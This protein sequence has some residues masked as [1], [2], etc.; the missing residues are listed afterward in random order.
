MNNA[1]RYFRFDAESFKVRVG[2][3]YRS[4]G[5]EEYTIKKIVT[6]RKFDKSSLQFDYSLIK[7]KS[8]MKFNS[9]ITKI[10][11]AKSFLKS[12]ISAVVIG[13]GEVRLYY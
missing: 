6:H 10:V 7:V 9:N 12:G 8:P 11:V 1:F 4:N 13:W 5:G 3:I 2:S